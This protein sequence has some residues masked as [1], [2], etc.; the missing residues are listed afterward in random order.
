ML[1]TSDISAEPKIALWVAL[2]VAEGPSRV[3]RGPHLNA[4]TLLAFDDDKGKTL[5]SLGADD[6]HMVAVHDV[7]SG[8]LLFMSSTTCRKPFDVAFGNFGS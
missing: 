4:I 3:I 1:A 2:N 7:T 6:R 5:V 8:Y